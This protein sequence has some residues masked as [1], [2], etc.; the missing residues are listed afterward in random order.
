MHNPSSS[1]L[2]HGIAVEGKGVDKDGRIVAAGKKSTLTIRLKPGRYTFY[3][4]FDHHK[5]LGMKGK[6]IVR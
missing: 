3:C 1:R 6:L 5:A 2:H 4:N